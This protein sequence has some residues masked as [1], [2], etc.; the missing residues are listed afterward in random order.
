MI[1]KLILDI[2]PIDG[3]VSAWS[4]DSSQ[5]LLTTMA[6]SMDEALTNIRMLIDDFIEN[7]WHDLP[8][9]QGLT[10]ADV[11]FEFEYSLSSFFDAFK[12]LKINEI[13]RLAK[14]NP[15]L[16]RAYA[17]GDKN[18]SLAQIEKIQEAVSRFAQSLLSVRVVPKMPRPLAA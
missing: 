16:V 5:G 13:A 17:N 14:L 8:E 18:A 4:S 10:S 6:D 9:W 2:D 12:A 11:Q 1:Y 7:E 3:V 15:A